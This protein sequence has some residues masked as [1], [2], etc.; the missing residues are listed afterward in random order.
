MIVSRTAADASI[1]IQQERD[2]TGRVVGTM[3]ANPDLALIGRAFGFAPT[4]ISSRPELDALP[5]I[6]AKPGPQFVIVETSLDAVWPQRPHER[7]S[8]NGGTFR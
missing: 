7:Q 3:F 8:G 1:W 6:L 2:Y 5:A 4:R